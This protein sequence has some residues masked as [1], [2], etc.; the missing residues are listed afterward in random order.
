M[1]NFWNW[2]REL[3]I[4]NCKKVLNHTTLADSLWASIVLW[5]KGGRGHG[6]HSSHL[7]S[8]CLWLETG[9][10]IV[11]Y[12]RVLYNSCSRHLLG[13]RNTAHTSR[14]SRDRPNTVFLKTEQV[15][16][17]LHLIGLMP[18]TIRISYRLARSPTLLCFT[19]LFWGAPEACTK[20]VLV[21]LGKVKLLY[22]GNLLLGYALSSRIICSPLKSS[23]TISLKSYK[24][25]PL[26]RY[27][28]SLVCK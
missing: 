18:V 17:I 23:E 24:L 16:H 14:L 27:S 25:S 7:T 12:R 13:H 3:R 21:Y 9:G 6:P 8:W 28:W 20:C 10:A 4:E 26:G 11:L 15:H 19:I 2:T 22:K 1:P 5:L